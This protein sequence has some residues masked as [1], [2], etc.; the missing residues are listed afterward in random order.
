VVP[1]TR[2]HRPRIEIEV[3]FVD[4][5]ERP[6]LGSGADDAQQIVLAHH[7]AGRIVGIG[8]SD[9][10]RPRTDPLE[11]GV[12]SDV[13]VAVKVDRHDGRPAQPGIHVEHGK[14]GVQQH[15]LIVVFEKRLE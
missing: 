10:F 6:V 5:Y 1:A 15:D 3:R 9:D 13:K 4:Q 12:A 2:R 7:S 8:D 11:Y 14:G